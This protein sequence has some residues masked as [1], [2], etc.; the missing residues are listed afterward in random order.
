MKYDPRQASTATLRIHTENKRKLNFIKFKLTCIPSGRLPVSNV[1]RRS[2]LRKM[3]LALLLLFIC[4]SAIPL[5]K[6]KYFVEK[7]PVPYDPNVIACTWALLL[8]QHA[9]HCQVYNGSLEPTAVLAFHLSD[10]ANPLIFRNALID[11]LCLYDESCNL[12]HFVNLCSYLTPFLSKVPSY[13]HWK[14]HFELHYYTWTYL[15]Y[16]SEAKKIYYDILNSDMSLNEYRSMERVYKVSLVFTACHCRDPESLDDAEN[17][18]GVSRD[19]KQKVFLKKC[20]NE[21]MIYSRL[22]RILSS[23]S[24]ELLVM[25]ALFD[26]NLTFGIQLTAR[27]LNYDFSYYKERVGDEFPFLSILFI[28]TYFDD[29]LSSF[30]VVDFN[31]FLL[32]YLHQSYSI[33]YYYLFSNEYSASEVE[34]VGA[35]SVDSDVP[36]S[37][38]SAADLNPDDF[39]PYRYPLPSYWF[40]GAMSIYQLDGF[41]PSFGVT[42]IGSMTS[43]WLSYLSHS[44][45]PFTSSDQ[46]TTV[47]SQSL[48]QL[49]TL[50][51]RKHLEVFVSSGIPSLLSS[52]HPMINNFLLFDLYSKVYSVSSTSQDLPPNDKAEKSSES[53][54]PSSSDTSEAEIPS[55]LLEELSDNKEIHILFED[56]IDRLQLLRRFML[57]GY[58]KENVES[59]LYLP[60]D[61]ALTEDDSLFSLYCWLSSG[62]YVSNDAAADGSNPSASSSSKQ[63]TSRESNELFIYDRIAK[64]EV[65]PGR[66]LDM[67]EVKGYKMSYCQ[68]AEERSPEKRKNPKGV[69]RGEKERKTIAE[70]KLNYF[71]RTSYRSLYTHSSYLP[72][73]SAASESSTPIN[74]RESSSKS[75]PSTATFGTSTEVAIITAVYGGYEKQCQ[76]YAKQSILTDFYCFTDDDSITGR[77]WFIDN[78]PYHLLELVN[79]FLHNELDELNCYHSNL[80]PFN[81]AKFYKQRFLHIP[82]VAAKNYSYI[83]WLDGSMITRHPHLSS[84]IRDLFL[85]NPSFSLTIF[86]HGRNNNL[87]LEV[88]Y[89]LK[90]EKYTTSNWR[91]ISQPLQQ[92][93]EQYDEYLKDG[94]TDG[95]WEGIKERWGWKSR[96]D[97]GVF[98]SCFLA[99]NMKK[100]DNLQRNEEVPRFLNAWAYENIHFSTQDQVSFSYV[101]FKTGISPL[102]LP[103]YGIYGNY[104]ANNIFTKSSHA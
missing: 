55:E 74:A 96:A 58:L 35:A 46:D 27:S 89:S 13:Y 95:Y 4:L 94:Y 71:Q 52:V 54:S 84:I 1:I 43:C 80:H 41:L 90:S 26:V 69:Q 23:L 85:Q 20:E 87:S 32:S 36:L 63:M 49:I 88:D 98:V 15:E 39:P 40:L 91:N 77:G 29:S 68:L 11:F 81:I 17:E 10:I 73:F 99:F 79:E 93:K 72:S 92:V 101:S 82:M 51:S 42:F 21:E 22:R 66:L 57:N 64:R 30:S 65:L 60:N 102:P 19:W 8:N 61:I 7:Y 31:E 33:D 25:I 45:A 12:S 53:A 38:P 59:L 56:C 103:G 62:C 28:E 104:L 14:P 2:T 9:V 100:K 24:S 18:D 48:S 34:E 5:V 83:I 47:K 6:L 3:E 86:E 44:S 50:F 97:Y 67:I 75:S 37:L 16:Q 70:T 76:L 78:I